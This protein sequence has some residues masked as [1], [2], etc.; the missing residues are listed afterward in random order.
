METEMEELEKRVA[1]LELAR[2]IDERARRPQDLATDL[3]LIE[4]IALHAKDSSD[5][6]AWVRGFID[7]LHRALDD[8]EMRPE[9]PD[10]RQFFEAG[11]R[12]IDACGQLWQRAA[13]RRPSRPLR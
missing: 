10:E 4:L 13:A 8:D 11:R 1:A 2:R 12:W 5:P 9:L 3:I 7:D 6:A